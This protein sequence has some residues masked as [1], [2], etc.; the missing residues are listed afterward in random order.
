[1]VRVV[2]YDQQHR[3]PGTN[4]SSVVLHGGLRTIQ[5]R[6]AD[7]GLRISFY[8][9]VGRRWP[10]VR[11]RWPVVVVVCLAVTGLV[12][13]GPDYGQVERKGASY[14]GRADEADLS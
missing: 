13:S 12:G 10:I 6:I 3:V 1:K 7:C 8:T 14:G 11:R 9:N 2:F 5:L 4:I